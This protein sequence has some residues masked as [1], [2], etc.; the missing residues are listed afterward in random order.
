MVYDQIALLA[1]LPPRVEGPPD[2]DRNRCQ[3]LAAP[4]RGTSV[5]NEREQAM[6]ANLAA[7]AKPSAMVSDP[8]VDDV[9]I[10]AR[11]VTMVMVKAG[12]NESMLAFPPGPVWLFFSGIST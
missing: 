4:L 3:S 7:S 10:L 1:H 11:Y 5:P 2:K 8:L 6:R 9:Y 12:R